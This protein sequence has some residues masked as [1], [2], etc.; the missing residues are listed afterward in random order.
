MN[1]TDLIHHDHTPFY[2][3]TIEASVGDNVRVRLRLPKE[4]KIESAFLVSLVS[5]ERHS[6]PMR[7]LE[8]SAQPNWQFFEAD[9][10]LHARTVRYMFWIITFDDTVLFSSRGAG[11]ANPSFRDW[12]QF[13]ADHHR[14]NWL[15]DRVFYQIFPDRF[16]NGDPSNDVKSGEYEYNGKPVI[17]KAWHEL[18]TKAGNVFEHWGGDLEGIRQGLDYLESLGVNGLYLNP[19][20][21]SPSNHRYDIEDYLN[22]DPHLGGNDALRQLIDEAHARGFKIVLDGVFNHTGD[23]L[24]AFKKARDNHPERALYTWLPNGKYEAFFGVPTLPKL[25][26]ASPLTFERFLEGEDAPVR[27]WLRFGADGWRLDVA[28]MMGARGIDANNLEVLR[29]LKVAARSEDPEA[30]IFGERFWDAEAALQGPNDTFGHDGGGEDGVMN[31]HGFTLPI[32]DWLSGMTIFDRPIRLETDE[33]AALIQERL[34]VIPPAM[35]LSQ[36]NLI[37]SHDIP[38]PLTR[39]GGDTAKL[40]T[41]FTLL[42][43]FPGVPGIYYGDEIGLSGGNDP[44][45]RAPFPWNENAWDHSVLEH[46]KAL[47]KARRS[48]LALQRGSLVWLAHTEDSIAYARVFTHADGRAENAIIAATR[49]TG[50]TLEIDVRKL[51]GMGWV[52]AV[53]GERVEARGDGLLEVS[54][55]TGILLI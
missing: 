33:L 9:L 5:G 45:C 50:E 48:S 36:Y 3:S 13:L 32:T 55:Q 43:G 35:Q 21:V 1:W 7:A 46:V 51:E 22:V 19:I 47:I 16:K 24:E 44:F 41:A 15:D 12:F 2:L 8:V 11:H 23:R 54:V 31:Y 14:P 28:H 25:D 42:L 27:H 39:L 20:F 53:T 37:G 17:Q 6:V 34:R 38:R 18:P 30:W 10:E 4:A 49:G 29:R 40:R 52:D 26:F